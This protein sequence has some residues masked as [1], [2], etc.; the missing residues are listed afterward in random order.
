[1]LQRREVSGLLHN[2][3]KHRIPRCTVVMAGS[4]LYFS[5]LSVAQERPEH[6]ARRPPP[7]ISVKMAPK[8]V[9]TPTCEQ[10]TPF[11]SRLQTGPQ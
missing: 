9:I 11:L 10:R 5:L 3:V 1:M 4:E 8:M 2:S 6:L 7:Q